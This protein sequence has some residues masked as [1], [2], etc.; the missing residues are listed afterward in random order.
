M[1]GSGGGVKVYFKEQQ[2]ELV[3]QLTSLF[4]LMLQVELYKTTAESL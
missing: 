1:G 2:S 4:A 3:D